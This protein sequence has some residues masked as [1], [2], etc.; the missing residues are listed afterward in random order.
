MNAV[1]FI[2]EL[3]GADNLRVPSE[4]LAQLPRSG[5]ARVIVL[6]EDESE[7]SIVRECVRRSAELDAGVAVEIAHDDVMRDARRAIGCA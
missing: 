3:S 2:T 1:E 7:T 5:R 6:T 4:I